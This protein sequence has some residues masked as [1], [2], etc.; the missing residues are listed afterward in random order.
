MGP[1]ATE[2][3]IFTAKESGLKSLYTLRKVIFLPLASLTPFHTSCSPSHLAWPC[4][5][6][7]PGVALSHQTPLK[8]C[9]RG[10][11]HITPC[12][13]KVPRELMERYSWMSASPP[14]PR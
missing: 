14:G 10:F 2:N 11:H 13:R 7:P 8:A 5:S 12:P 9:A 6:Q 1:P 4:I 3:S